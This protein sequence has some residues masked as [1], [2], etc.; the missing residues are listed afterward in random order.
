MKLQ[1]QRYNYA[2]PQGGDCFRTCIACVIGMDRDEV[3]HWQASS[4]EHPSI[5]AEDWLNARGL[6]FEEAYHQADS[7]QAA[8]DW[9]TAWVGDEPFLFYG[10]TRR[11][12]C[13][14][15]IA[16][17]GKIVWDPANYDASVIGP[18][19][20]CGFYGGAIVRRGRNLAA[21]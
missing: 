5:Q 13:H 11:G 18:M 19:P 12:T 6:E 2:D 16:Q 4:G 17:R 10:Q 9:M 8:L 15:V 7:V 21:A 14:C 20:E 1:K 3:P